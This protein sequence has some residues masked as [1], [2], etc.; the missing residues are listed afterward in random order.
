MNPRFPLCSCIVHRRREGPAEE[1]LQPLVPAGQDVPAASV[2][3][4]GGRPA[5]LL[6]RGALYGGRAQREC[7]CVCVRVR[8]EATPPEQHLT[9]DDKALNP[10]IL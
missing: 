2:A 4:P 7:V 6:L 10:Q 3:Q 5:G 8:E 1:V 9:L